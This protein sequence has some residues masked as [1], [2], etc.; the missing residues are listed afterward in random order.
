SEAALA[1]FGRGARDA[2]VAGVVL[3]GTTDLALYAGAGVGDLDVPSLVMTAKEDAVAPDD[4]GGDLLWLEVPGPAVRVSIDKAC[5]DVFLGGGCARIL[6]AEGQRVVTT[7]ALAWARRELLGDEGVAGVLAG[8]DVVSGLAAVSVKGVPRFPYAERLAA[9]LGASV[10]MRVERGLPFGEVA[11]GAARG[12][13]LLDYATTASTIDPEGFVGGTPEPVQ[14]TENLWADFTWFG[15]WAPVVLSPFPHRMVGG[16]HEAGILGTDFLALNVYALD[17]GGG[18]VFRADGAG[19]DELT[20]RGAG[21][22]PLTVE[23]RFSSDPS[24]LPGFRPNV[25]AVPIAIGGARAVA[26]LDTGFEDGVVPHAV[27]VNQALFDAIEAAGVALERDFEKD[28]LLTTCVTGVAEPAFAF[29]LPEGVSVELVGEDGAAVASWADAEIYLK[30]TPAS[31]TVCGGIG[32]WEE[33]GAQIG[34]S[35]LGEGG[36]LLL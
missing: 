7:Y 29:R 34:A 31:A 24:S 5:H 19:C 17:Y 14:G 1:A 4:G 33:P 16:V 15:G 32:T 26:Q 6:D 18:Q 13:F 28:V 27:N 11:I 3:M 10:P 36:F 25:P 22:A 12:W 23:G 9:C 20:L 30:Q 21:L 2:R 35:L 8:H